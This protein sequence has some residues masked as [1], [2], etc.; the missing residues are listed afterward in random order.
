M[1]AQSGVSS[2]INGVGGTLIAAFD[3]QKSDL[4]GIEGCLDDK[5]RGIIR[6][7]SQFRPYD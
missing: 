6:M 2:C 1:K 5:F 3:R 4:K 7:M